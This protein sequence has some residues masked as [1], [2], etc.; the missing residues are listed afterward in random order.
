MRTKISS[1]LDSIADRLE[2]KG[3][4]KEAFEIDKVADEIEGKDLGAFLV[5][6]MKKNGLVPGNYTL[7]PHILQDFLHGF[8]V[9]RAVV[10]E[11]PL[12]PG[13]SREEWV[14]KRISIGI[15]YKTISQNEW[16]VKAQEYYVQPQESFQVRGTIEQ[17]KN[18]FK[19][20]L[21]QMLRKIREKRQVRH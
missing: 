18:Q 13:T 5:D 2:K 8:L 9:D 1:M 14:E 7:Y 20:S 15:D 19:S 6:T 21:E 4:V 11:E 16:V 10:F 3:L 17:V 12:Q